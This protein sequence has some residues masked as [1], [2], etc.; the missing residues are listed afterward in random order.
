MQTSTPNN[1]TVDILS[2]NQLQLV[3]AEKRTVLA[4]MRIGISMLALPLAIFSALI[5]TSKYY[6]IE[7]V[8]LVLSAI[9]VINISLIVVAAYLIVHALIRLRHYDK[10]IENLKRQHESLRPLIEN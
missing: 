5:A 8:W 4:S 3:L 7:H 1:T 2:I 10:M 6:E 9:S